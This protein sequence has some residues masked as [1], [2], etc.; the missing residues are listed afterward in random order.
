MID[1]EKIELMKP[2]MGSASLLASCY[3][4][5]NSLHVLWKNR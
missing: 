2:I 5:H 4:F 3:L 1:N